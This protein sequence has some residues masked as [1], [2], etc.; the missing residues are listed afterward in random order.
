MVQ[1][2]CGGIVADAVGNGVA[3]GLV[4]VAQV[5][6][7]GWR[8]RYNQGV[9]WRPGLAQMPARLALAMAWAAW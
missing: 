6:E 7:E 8:H 3:I 4:E 5:I 1:G 2:K 9:W